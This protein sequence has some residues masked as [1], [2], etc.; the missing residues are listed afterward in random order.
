MGIKAV[1]FDLDDTLLWDE[2]SVQEAFRATCE[3]AS[4]VT[5]VDPVKLEEAVRRE[6]RALYESYETFPFTKM[7]GINPFEGLWA[8]FTSG[9]QE[10]FRKLEALAPGYRTASWTRG[11]LALG[12]DDPELGY[13]L[14]ELFPAERRSRPIVYEETFEVLDSLKGRYQLLLLTN[15][16]PDLQK[17]KLAG[18]PELVPYF[19]HIIIS[20]EFGRGKPNPAIFE[21]A[22]SL[23]GIKPEEGL[24]VGDK[25]TTDI[26]GSNAIGM[27]S[28]W[29]NRH[30]ITRTDEII[31]VH[32]IRSLRDIQ[33]IIDSIA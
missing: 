9:E 19:D 33:D 22:V 18:V 14:G 30:E 21:H 6:A 26:M 24:M 3:E 23:L 10:E 5:G 4:R 28:L 20:G 12:I 25:L 8:N 27:R 31:P 17:E 15:G 2:R 32:E 7:I 16:S 11:L 13:R 1:L 29:I